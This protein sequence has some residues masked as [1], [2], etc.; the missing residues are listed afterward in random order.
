LKDIIVDIKDVSI[1]EAKIEKPLYLYS[2]GADPT[3]C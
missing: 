3:P 1:D 2:I